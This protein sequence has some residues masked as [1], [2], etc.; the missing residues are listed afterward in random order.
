MYIAAHSLG[1]FHEASSWDACKTRWLWSQVPVPAS[2][3]LSAALR[4]GGGPRIHRR[5]AP[6]PARGGDGDHRQREA[7]AADLTAFAELDRL[8]ATSSERTGRLDILVANAGV[9][10][11]S[12]LENVTEAPTTEYSI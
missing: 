2:D 7:V 10:G 8:F 3:W 11:P 5:P 4:R 1:F 12:T 6:G 9:T